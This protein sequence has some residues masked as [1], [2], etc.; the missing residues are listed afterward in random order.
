M[1]IHDTSWM[2]PPSLWVA[3]I[4]EPSTKKT[5]ILNETWAPLPDAP[6]RRRARLHGPTGA[7]ETPAKSRAE[8]VSPPPLPTRLIS[9]DA[10]IES[11]LQNI[12]ANQDR[13]VAMMFDELASLIGGMDRYNNNGRGGSERA[14]F[15]R[16]YTGGPHIV[17]RVSRGIV[18][19]NN[20][21]L[22]VCGGIQPD[23]LASF[24]DPDGRRIM[25]AAP[26][27][28]SPP[29]P[30]SAWMRPIPKASRIYTLRLQGLV[31]ASNGHI[32]ALSSRSE[33]NACRRRGR[34]IPRRTTAP[35]RS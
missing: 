29:A 5:P 18:S 27:Q 2:V 22:T 23:R 4:G 35:T 7:V 15:L 25:A 14:F 9:N 26:A 10:T 19:L 20:L 12:L 1:K 30:A 16:A 34:T 21:L 13:G 8:D 28:S 31:D 6:N 17:D 24:K 33:R 11:F 3:L 32:A